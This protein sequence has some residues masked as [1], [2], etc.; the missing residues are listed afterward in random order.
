MAQRLQTRRQHRAG[1]LRVEQFTQPA[2][3][4]GVEVTRQ[5]LYVMQRHRDHAGIAVTGGHAVDHAF[6][7]QQR[8]E[9]TRA[10]GDALAVGGIALQ[11][12]RHLAVGQCQ[13]VFNAQRAFAE[14]YRLKRWRRHR[15]SRKG[16]S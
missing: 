5:G 4:E 13:H 2:T 11:L 1:G 12:R 15:S 8:V 10:L 16:K 7:V 3:V 14:G 6:L 9:K